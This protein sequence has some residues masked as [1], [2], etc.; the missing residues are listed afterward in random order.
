MSTLHNCVMDSAWSTYAPQQG[1]ECN[2]SATGTIPRLASSPYPLSPSGL[3][4]ALL[5]QLEDREISLESIVGGF[6]TTKAPFVPV[7]ANL[8]RPVR[9]AGASVK[10]ASK[11]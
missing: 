1:R 2:L 5:Q 8:A 4:F 11:W 7:A 6:V 9:G 3:G 10:P